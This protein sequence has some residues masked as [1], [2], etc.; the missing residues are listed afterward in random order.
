MSLVAASELSKPLKIDAD[1]VFLDAG[2]GPYPVFETGEYDFTG[3]QYLGIDI[4]RADLELAGQADASHLDLPPIFI[5][6]DVRQLPLPD[7][8]LDIIFFGDVFGWPEVDNAYR[9][10]ERKK[11]MKDW[12]EAQDIHAP[13]PPLEQWQDFV[14]L[15]KMLRQAQRTL[16]TAGKLIL[17]ETLTPLPPDQFYTPMLQETG[18]SEHQRIDRT[19]TNVPEWTDTVKPFYRD[20]QSV[21]IIEPSRDSRPLKFILFADKT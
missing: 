8:S 7:A 15:H 3:V 13:M 9:V 12:K 21:D 6:G 5:H 18:F 19:A 11:R 2:C 1:R 4:H 20:T 10:T 14:S 16:K 17:L